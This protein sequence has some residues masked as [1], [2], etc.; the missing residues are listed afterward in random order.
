M[1]AGQQSAAEVA[2]ILEQATYL[3]IS[4]VPNPKDLSQG[5]P[6]IPFLPNLIYGMSLV[7]SPRRHVIHVAPPS[8]QCGFRTR[9][10]GGGQPVAHQQLNLAV[11]P[12]NYQA[13][14]GR[15]PPPV[16][17]APMRPPRLVPTR[18]AGLPVN[19][20]SLRRRKRPPK[21]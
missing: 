7:E 18:K 12:N 5:T 21:P 17:S 6:L 13:G 16:A 8:T 10:V 4:T 14:A 9:T 11:M 3:V 15:T 19:R 20:I 2:A 1:T